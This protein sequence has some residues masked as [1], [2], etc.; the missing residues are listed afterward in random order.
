MLIDKDSHFEKSLNDYSFGK[1]KRIIK[2]SEYKKTFSENNKYIGRYLVIWVR[3][4]KEDD[5]RVGIIA[6][7]KMHNKANKRNFAKRRIKEIFRRIRPYLNKNKD[8]V[9]IS[10]KSLLTSSW[11]EI[12]KE[13]IDLLYKANV[14]T[15]TNYEILKDT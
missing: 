14:I 2:T 8:L 1:D 6:S 3:T 15:V 11:I 7:K 13:L 4:N 12:K 10:R 5:L 9:I